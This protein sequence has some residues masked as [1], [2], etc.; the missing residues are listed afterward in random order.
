MIV[1]LFPVSLLVEYIWIHSYKILIIFP[2]LLI[3][4]V[5]YVYLKNFS[6]KITITEN[7][8]SSKTLFQKISVPLSSII[9]FDIMYEDVSETRLSQY[10]DKIALLTADGGYHIIP[11]TFLR[12]CHKRELII[13]LSELIESYK[14]VTYDRGSHSQPINIRVRPLS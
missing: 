14:Q 11:I 7:S 4:L 2:L 12:R 5:F 6:L 9:S 3:L 1:F 10:P 8:I 13:V